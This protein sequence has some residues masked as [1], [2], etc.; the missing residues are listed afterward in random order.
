MNNRSCNNCKKPL[1]GKQAKYCS[2]ACANRATARAK[3]LRSEATPVPTCTWEACTKPARSR[4]AKLC[5]Q[6]YH[7]IYRHGDA[8]KT[9]NAPTTPSA[10]P[11]RRYRTAYAPRHA[12]AMANGNVY[13]H[14]RVLYD[15]LGPGEH[16]CHWCGVPVHWSTRGDKLGLYPDHVNGL[17]DDNRAEN[18]VPS[19]LSCNSG[20]GA[21]ARSAE[22]KRNGWWSGHDTIA[23][24]SRGGRR[25]PIEEPKPSLL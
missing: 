3:H 19:C 13:V 12:L 9:A 5:P 2:H 24:L 25:E 16:P 14:R 4:S 7:R 15:I 18:L 21:Q 6:H 8:N 1:V 23:R 17:G 11:G 22:L 20:R 10:S